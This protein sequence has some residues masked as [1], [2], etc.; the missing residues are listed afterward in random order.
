MRLPSSSTSTTWK[1]GS[2]RASA[3]QYPPT[4]TVLG[5]TIT[6]ALRYVPEYICRLGVVGELEVMPVKVLDGTV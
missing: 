2:T 5:Q 1:H 3:E 6:L 4:V